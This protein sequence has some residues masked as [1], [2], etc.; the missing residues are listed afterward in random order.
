MVPPRAKN[1]SSQKAYD[2]ENWES[3]RV[4]LH[5]PA[6]KI[7]LRIGTKQNLRQITYLYDLETLFDNVLNLIELLIIHERMRFLDPGSTIVSVAAAAT[8]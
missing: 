7:G 8:I 5:Q 6:A 4:D 1:A 2:I 3:P